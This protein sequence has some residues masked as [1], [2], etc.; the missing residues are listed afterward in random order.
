MRGKVLAL[1]LMFLTAALPV[2]ALVQ[3]SLAQLVGPRVTVATA[4][5]SFLFLCGWLRVRT[6]WVAR[7]DDGRTVV[8]EATPAR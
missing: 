8:P 3:G 7:M 2:G 4:G 5:V 1:Y 6:G